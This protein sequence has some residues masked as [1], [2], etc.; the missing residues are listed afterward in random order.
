MSAI[1]LIDTCVLLNILNVPG[2]NQD[3]TLIDREFQKLVQ[4]GDT[5]LLPMATI[6]ETGS[7]I[8]DIPNGHHRRRWG[9]IFVE[10]IKETHQRN[11]PWSPIAFPDLDSIIPWLDEYPDFAARSVGFANVTIIKDWE[12][13]CDRHPMSRVKIWSIDGGLKGYDRKP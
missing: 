2:Y 3:R 8:A 4:Q 6:L 7:H 1:V 13:V 5:L 10:Q 12:K 11:A 9:E